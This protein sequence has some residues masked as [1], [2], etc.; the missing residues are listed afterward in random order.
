MLGRSEHPRDNACTC[1]HA[2]CQI[3]SQMTPNHKPDGVG[4]E[5][6]P[7]GWMAGSTCKLRGMCEQCRWNHPHTTNTSTHTYTKYKTGTQGLA[8]SQAASCS[9]ES[10]GG[11]GDTTSRIRPASHEQTHTYM[12]THART[13]THAHMTRHASGE[14]KL[15]CL[16]RNVPVQTRKVLTTGTESGEAWVCTQ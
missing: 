3:D 8:H 1:L 7:T 6:E 16:T 12:P 10:A 14:H 5:G 13:H 11:H 2:A 15:A 4:E 9:P